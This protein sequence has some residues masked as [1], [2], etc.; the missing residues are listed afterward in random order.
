MKLMDMVFFR[1]I[2]LSSGLIDKDVIIREKF[3][4][5][6]LFGWQFKEGVT[7]VFTPNLAFHGET[8]QADN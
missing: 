6:Q 8:G 4:R 7:A 3:H 1:R 5:E 2:Q